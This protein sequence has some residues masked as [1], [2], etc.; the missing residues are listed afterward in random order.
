[1][2]V[3]ECGNDVQNVVKTIEARRK[4]NE[5]SCQLELRLKKEYLTYLF[6]NIIQTI[7]RVKNQ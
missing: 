4:E 6:K 2:S 5:C 3:C 7:R 1:M